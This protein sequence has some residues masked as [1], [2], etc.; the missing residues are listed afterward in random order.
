[1]GLLGRARNLMQGWSGP[2]P[3][4]AQ[5]FHVACSEGHRLQ[6]QRTEGYQA[7][8]CPTCGEGIFV[9]PRSPLPDPPAP[10]GPERARIASSIEAIYEDD[11]IPLTDP[12]PS[13]PEPGVEQAGSQ[14]ES[15][16]EIDWVDEA[17]EKAVT[18]PAPTKPPPAPKAR[19]AARE[20]LA[21]LVVGDSPAP[22]SARAQAPRRLG[23]C[24]R[25]R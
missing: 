14:D 18:T 22:V 11:P 17:A 10:A 6:G 19:P 9:L 12:I 3:A 8:R 13:H 1:M 5:A 20:V 24:M 23:I 21:P 2:P 15:E 4:R 7:L 16:A 25:G